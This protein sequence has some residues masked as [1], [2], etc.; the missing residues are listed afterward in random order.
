MKVKALSLF[1]SVFFVLSS[2]AFSANIP[3]TGETWVYGGIDYTYY[4][5]PPTPIASG[6]VYTWDVYGSTIVAQNTDPAAGPLYVTVQWPH[7]LSQAAIGIADNMGNSGIIEVITNGFAA[8]TLQNPFSTNEKEGLN[9][10]KA[11]YTYVLHEAID[12]DNKKK[13]RTAIV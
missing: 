11:A 13:K 8:A 4:A 2:T 12:P 6:T 7:I 5:T 3:I 10:F 1:A 9:G